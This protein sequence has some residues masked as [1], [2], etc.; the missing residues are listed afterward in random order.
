MKKRASPFRKTKVRMAVNNN[1]ATTNKAPR[2]RMRWSITPGKIHPSKNM[3]RIDNGTNKAAC[4]DILR[5]SF[6][7]FFPIIYP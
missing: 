1:T 6:V 5:D 7:F 4:A 2:M 3:G